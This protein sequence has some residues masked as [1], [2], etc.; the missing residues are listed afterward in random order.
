MNSDRIESDLTRNLTALLR[1]KAVDRFQN[2]PGVA[3]IESALYPAD[4]VRKGSR[5]VGEAELESRELLQDAAKD[6]ITDGGR[7]LG[8]HACPFTG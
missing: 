7:R 4:G 6:D 1:P 3:H 5:P 8:R 2:T